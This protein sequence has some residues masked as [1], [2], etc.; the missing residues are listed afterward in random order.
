GD[1]VGLREG[2]IVFS[3]D[4]VV[5]VRV[6]VGGIPEDASR[7]KPQLLLQSVA[8]SG[9]SDGVSAVQRKLRSE[10]GVQVEVVEQAGASGLFGG[11][12]LL[13]VVLDER[14]AA[15]GFAVHRILP[16]LKTGTT[17]PPR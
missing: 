16:G 1:V 14:G 9:E 8:R 3:R 15:V 5:G 10:V 12:E 6:S 2:L 4:D 7:I 13:Q 17:S 11:C